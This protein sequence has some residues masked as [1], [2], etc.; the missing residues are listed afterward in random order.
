[1]LGLYSIC[2]AYTLELN[3][4]KLA[5]TE[6]V[7]GWRNADITWLKQRYAIGWKNLARSW[8]QV[9]EFLQ[10]ETKQSF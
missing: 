3:F 8:N 4:H 1:M 6:T 9:L 10:R 5:T 7:D 2:W